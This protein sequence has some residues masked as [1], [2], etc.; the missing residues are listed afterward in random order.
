MGGMAGNVRVEYPGAIYH[1]TV[2]ANGRAERFDDDDD[3]RY[4]LGRIA[5]AA[6]TYQGRVYLFCIGV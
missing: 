3:R 1:L 4:L 6:S 2:R 5:E